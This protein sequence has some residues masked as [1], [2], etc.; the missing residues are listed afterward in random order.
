MM[1]NMLFKFG[2]L[3]MVYGIF[4]FNYQLGQEYAYREAL[5]AFREA[6]TDQAFMSRIEQRR[7]EFEMTQLIRLLNDYRFHPPRSTSAR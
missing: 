2:W 5:M 1:S 3:S 6:Q 7:N 4:N